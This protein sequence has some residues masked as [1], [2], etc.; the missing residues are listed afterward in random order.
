VKDRRILLVFMEKDII[1][2][3]TSQKSEYFRSCVVCVMLLRPC[4]TMTGTHLRLWN[5]EKLIAFNTR[6]DPK[7]LSGI[8]HHQH[9]TSYYP[10]SVYFLGHNPKYFTLKYGV[11][12]EEFYLFKFSNA[13][14]IP[15]GV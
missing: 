3:A 2:G 6:T 5:N 15:E 4:H 9:H 12:N 13:Q 14:G 7:T 8:S 11:E 10:S 1:T